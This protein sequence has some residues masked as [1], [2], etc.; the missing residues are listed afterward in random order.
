MPTPAP[1]ADSLVEAML[2]RCAAANGMLP[3]EVYQRLF[4][5]TQDLEE[6]PI[7]EI[8]TAHAAATIAIGLGCKAF[9]K[10]HPITTV[11]LFGGRFSSRRA[12]G[13]TDR[14]YQIVMQNLAQAGLTDLVTVFK[15]S[16]VDFAASPQCP[17]RLSMLMLDADG[18]IDRDF[19]L[20]YTK[21]PAGGLI[22]ID[23]ADAD[24]FLSFNAD[25]EAYVDLK[26]R[27]TH[28]LVAALQENGYIR[29]LEMVANTLFCRS[30]GRE[31]DGDAFRAMAL[32]AYRGLVFSE[33]DGPWTDLAHLVRT[34]ARARTALSFYNRFRWCLD[35][36]ERFWRRFVR[37]GRSSVG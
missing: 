20:F 16:S 33:V 21:L 17:Q 4:A 1:A 19:L 30:T 28:L 3:Q 24:V 8:G 31:L 6:G 35:P 27:I 34:P 37:G 23:D 15:G 36:L 11:D 29:D 25:R 14:N 10:T 9:A 12:Y 22:V 7:V 26:H 5:V 13:D 18:R 2:A 32:E